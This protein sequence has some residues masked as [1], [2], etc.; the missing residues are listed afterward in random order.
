MSYNT[1]T[2]VAGV[3][4]LSETTKYSFRPESAC[5]FA[6]LQKQLSFYN[7]V[8]IFGCI[9]TGAVYSQS[10]KLSKSR[11]SES[12]NKGLWKLSESRLSESVLSEGRLTFVESSTT[13]LSFTTKKFWGSFLS[14]KTSTFHLTVG[15]T[16]YATLSRQ[17]NINFLGRSQC[18]DTN[19]QSDTL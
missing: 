11:L 16:T 8:N 14:E 10:Y 6:F 12:S 13:I 7:C 9:Y 4:V 2:R 15:C 3:G 19:I 17:H 5:V 18:M 1:K